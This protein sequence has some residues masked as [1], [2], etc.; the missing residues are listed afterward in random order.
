MSTDFIGDLLHSGVQ[1]AP[2]R[3]EGGIFSP[4]LDAS[5]KYEDI[6]PTGY[7]ERECRLGRQAPCVAEQDDFLVLRDL[8]DAPQNLAPFD[9]G[10]LIEPFAN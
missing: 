7:A 3:L 5:L 1:A 4:A 10:S 8:A 6:L 9:G 2:L